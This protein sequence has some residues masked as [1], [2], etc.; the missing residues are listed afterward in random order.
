MELFRK[1]LFE[2]SKPFYEKY[3]KENP[4]NHRAMGQY[5]SWFALAYKKTQDQPV[6]KATKK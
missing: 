1:Q 2:E 6:K 5:V 4:T 3:I